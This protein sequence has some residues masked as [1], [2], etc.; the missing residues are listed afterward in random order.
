MLWGIGRKALGLQIDA[1]QGIGYK[2][3]EKY[4]VFKNQGFGVL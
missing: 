2:C 3:N 4:P 1:K